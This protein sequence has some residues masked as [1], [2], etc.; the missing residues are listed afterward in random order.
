VR[1]SNDLL[2]QS[3]GPSQAPLSRTK[4]SALNAPG[5]PTYCVF[6]GLQ[7]ENTRGL[8]RFTSQLKKHLER[9]HWRGLTYPR[10]RW[11][12]SVGRVL[13][14]QLVEPMWLELLSPDIAVYPHNVLPSRFVSHR[15]LRVLVLHDVLF[16][17]NSNRNAGNRYRSAKLKRSLVNAD[18]I[19]T[20]SATSGAEI[21]RLLPSEK[22]IMVIPNA[23]AASFESFSSAER[24]NSD[25]PAR[26]LHFGGHATSKNTKM[27]FEAVSM[28][29][30]DG[31][32]VHLMLAA[33]SAE[34]ELVE[35]WRREAGLP[36][37]ALT[38]LPLL[39]DEDLKQVYREAA[40]HCMPST[41]E[42]FGIPVIEAARCGTTNVLSPLPV[43]KELIGDDAIFANS[44][45][46]ESI[47]R[48]MMECLAADVSPIRERARA[49]TDRFL[50][51]SVHNLDAIPVF[52]AIEEM[53]LSRQRNLS[54][55]SH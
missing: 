12:S 52:R 27:V 29:K 50:F 42:G 46:A 39:S 45:G 11:K 33:M 23:L 28:L 31:R 40:V 8:G 14:N 48:A 19:I 10:P 15:S 24:R 36:A 30:R 44:L 3:K 5:P 18:L 4:E 53:A 13:L 51:E 37:E 55:K 2:L 25:S 47:A 22:K 9:M 54:G 1:K 35:R 41:G 20:V 43:F 6:D 26:I 49:R 21:R 32:D 38:V 16:L 7:W 17:D 34:A